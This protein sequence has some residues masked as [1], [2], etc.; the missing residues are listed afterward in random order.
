VKVVEDNL[1]NLLVNLLLLPQDNVTFPLNRAD[2]E[3]RTGKDVGDD[4]DGLGNVLRE[5]LGVVD[6]L[7]AG[8]VGVEVGTEVLNLELELVLGALAGSLE[9]HV[10]E[11]VGG[12]GG[13]VGLGATSSVDPD[14]DGR[15]GGG[16]GGLGSDGEAVREGGDLSEGGGDGGG[17][18]TEGRLRAGK[19]EKV[20]VSMFEGKGEISVRCR[21]AASTLGSRP[22]R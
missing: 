4:L 13:L 11:E 7:L 15:G 6:G 16:G 19:E 5:R 22:F 14:T 10:L 21:I 18:A 8:G 12:S 3:L 2:L 17:E 9:R 1:L 20:R